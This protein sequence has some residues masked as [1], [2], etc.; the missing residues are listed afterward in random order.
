MLVEVPKLK[1][2]VGAEV[3]VDPWNDVPKVKDMV[4]QRFEPRVFVLHYRE[5][6]FKFELCDNARRNCKSFVCFYHKDRN[7]NTHIVDD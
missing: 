3:E 5:Y 7:G 4:Q 2:P 1:A 6:S